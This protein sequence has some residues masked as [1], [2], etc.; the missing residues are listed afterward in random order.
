M[1]SLN[2]IQLIGRLG[3]DPESRYIPSGKKK[4]TFSLAVDRKWKTSD[5]EVKEAT[6]WFNV[7]AW[8]RLGDICDQY[9]SKGRLVYLEGQLRTDRYEHENETRYFTRVI[10]SN[11]QMLD[12]KAEEE[13]VV[14]EEGESLPGD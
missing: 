12:Y 4:S 13:E 11:M 3:K 5:G 8:G 2:R 7:E 1:P 6:D 14:V 9:L 10:L